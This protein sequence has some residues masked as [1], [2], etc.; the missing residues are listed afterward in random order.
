MLLPTRLSTN[1]ESGAQGGPEFKTTITTLTSGREQRNQDWLQQRGRWDVS[2]GIQDMEDLQEVIDLFYAARGRRHSFMFKDFQDYVGDVEFLGTGDG[3]E[4]NFQIVRNYTVGAE[5]YRR[6]IFFPIESTITVLR[7]NA[8]PSGTPAPVS[9]STW[10]LQPGGI[11]R[12]TAPQTPA[13][14]DL[15][16]ATFEYD[17]LVRFDIDH[18]RITTEFEHLGGLPSIPVIELR[19][20]DE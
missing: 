18:L 9:D 7:D 16:Y 17:V 8:P 2:Y 1:I 14:D 12:F 13:P 4:R 19:Y 15:I 6:E 10:S 3:S 11:I 5:T 20:G